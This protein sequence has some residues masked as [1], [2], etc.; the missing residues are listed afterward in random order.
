M[1]LLLTGAG[2]FLG[3]RLFFFYRKKYEIWAPSRGELDLTDPKAVRSGVCSFKPDV[4]VHCAA[5]SDVGTCEKNPE[6]SL[7][8]NVQGTR[9][10]AAACAPDGALCARPKFLFCSSDQ[11]Y[12]DGP[13]EGKYGMDFLAHQENEILHPI[14]VYGQHKLL[15]EQACRSLCPDSV[16]LRLS[17]MYGELT[18][19]ERGKGRQN[20]GEILRRMARED[21]EWP[22]SDG[23]YRGVTDVWE[24]VRHLETALSLPPGI[25]NFG[26]PNSVSLYETARRA[27]KPFGKEKLA[28]PA[29]GNRPR[30][31]CMDPAKALE[32]GIRFPDTALGLS[33]F[34]R[35]GT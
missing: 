13:A 28:C 30:N 8:V 9:N 12:F 22:F 33:G 26:S 10:L 16:I 15:A 24:V 4:V 17:W 2:G 1:R 34:L 21:L 14:P 25:Y 6:L 3:S 20:L 18:E 23:D 35:A 5:I 19:K 11:V 27:L 32:H 7:A 29:G 31:L